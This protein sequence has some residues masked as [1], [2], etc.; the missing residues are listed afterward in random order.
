MQLPTR[1]EQRVLPS[2]VATATATDLGC[3]H[4]Y[5]YVSWWG[6]G[7]YAAR[8]TQAGFD[9]FQ[10]RAVS[11][12]NLETLTWSAPYIRASKYTCADTVCLGCLPA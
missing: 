11:L 12:L 10:R 4:G 8:T 6:R 1:R 3:D 9:C 5:G 2:L 7:C